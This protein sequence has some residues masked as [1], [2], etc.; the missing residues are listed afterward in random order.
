MHE[1]G[2][3]CH[4]PWI[5]DLGALIGGITGLVSVFKAFFEGHPFSYLEPDEA[6]G[7]LKLYVFNTAK[8]SIVINGSYILPQKRWYIAPN[9]P[10]VTSE[11][12]ARSFYGA[13]A[14]ANTN[15]H[16]HNLIIEPGRRHEFF[17]GSVDHNAKL[18]SC[19]VFMFWQPLGGLSL[20]PRVPLLLRSSKAQMERLFQARK[21]V[22]DT[23]P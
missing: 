20:I 10:N 15:W 2:L 3:L 14:S 8:G 23:V 6:K 19:F 12:R 5:R 21:C 1:T 13:Q 22:L 11:G 17:L 7:I 4:W 18:T 16:R 9:A